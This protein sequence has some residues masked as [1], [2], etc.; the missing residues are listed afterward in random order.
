MAFKWTQE[1]VGA[2]DWKSKTTLETLDACVE[3][4]EE[5]IAAG[6]YD[7]LGR[8]R[9]GEDYRG[10]CAACKKWMHLFEG[11]VECPLAPHCCNGLWQ[12]MDGT[13]ERAMDVLNYIK[14]V[15]S[16]LWKDTLVNYLECLVDFFDD[17]PRYSALVGKLRDKYCAPPP[18][19]PWE[20]KVGD[21]VEYFGFG[22][23]GHGKVVY[24]SAIHDDGKRDILVADPSR[25]DWHNG[26]L[27]D[28]YTRLFPNSCF[29]FRSDDI[30]PMEK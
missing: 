14:K 7:P 8:D 27:G 24:I 11:C 4:W 30:R 19:P 13:R 5:R 26:H 6:R 28:D 1:T 25:C 16:D 18:P 23:V 9:D 20:P 15:R 21:W 12:K 2:V 10:V 29:Y 22:Y 17:D 3:H